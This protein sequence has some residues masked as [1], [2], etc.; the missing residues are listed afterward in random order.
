MIEQGAVVMLQ[1]AAITSVS[2]LVFTAGLTFGLAVCQTWPKVKGRIMR[3]FRR[4]RFVV[5]NVVLGPELWRKEGG[6]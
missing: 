6:I 3:T 1:W 2:I 4:S 5:R